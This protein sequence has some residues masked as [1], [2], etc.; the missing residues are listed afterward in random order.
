MGKIQGSDV[1]RT[2]GYVL[3]LSNTIPA[4]QPLCTPLSQSTCIFL[5]LL[6]SPILVTVAITGLLSFTGLHISGKTGIEK[7]WK[8]PGW[9]EK[10]ICLGSPSPHSGVQGHPSLLTNASFDQYEASLA[11]LKSFLGEVF[12]TFSRTSQ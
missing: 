2:L 5:M 3:N 10:N 7:W 12:T 11:L 4:E 6:F 1:G 8:S 9:S